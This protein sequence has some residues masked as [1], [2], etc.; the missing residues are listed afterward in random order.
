LASLKIAVIGYKADKGHKAKR[1]KSKFEMRD[2]V[3]FSSNIKVVAI[4]NL[5]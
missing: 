2:K 1:A 3:V 4:D 5:F